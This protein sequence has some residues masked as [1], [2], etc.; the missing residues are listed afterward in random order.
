MEFIAL[1]AVFLETFPRTIMS[2]R[3]SGAPF[4]AMENE[5]IKSFALIAMFIFIFSPAWF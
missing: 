2:S 4:G 3:F 1:I 5:K